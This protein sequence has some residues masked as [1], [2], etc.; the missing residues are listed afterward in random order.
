ML[1]RCPIPIREIH[2]DNG[3]EFMNHHL[4]QFFRDKAKGIK[5]SRSRPYQKND[6]RFVE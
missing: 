5:L 3:P 4:L 1:E 2:P 6:N